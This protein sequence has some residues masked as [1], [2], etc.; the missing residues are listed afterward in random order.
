MHSFDKIRILLLVSL[1]TA[2]IIP[3]ENDII[4]ILN[5]KLRKLKTTQIEYVFIIISPG[6]CCV[7]I[8]N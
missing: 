8:K 6:D 5:F 1:R 2:H 4:I 7:K 3:G